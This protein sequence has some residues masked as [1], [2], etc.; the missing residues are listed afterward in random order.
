[1][2][3]SHEAAAWGTIAVL[4]LIGCCG[5]GLAWIGRKYWLNARATR[6]G[7]G[8]AAV[9]DRLDYTGPYLVG[10][11]FALVSFRDSAGTSHAAKLVL[12]NL[13][14]NRL[15]EGQP[16]RILYSATDPQSVTL[17]GRRMRA[18]SEAAGAISVVL[19]LLIAVTAAWILVGGLL[20]WGGMQS[21]RPSDG[22]HG[23][24]VPPPQP[25]N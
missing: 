25:R 20:G 12:P 2:T 13:Q 18:L 24:Y 15:R 8:A 9:I 10:R 3:Q 16:I 7:I 21:L 6:G 1:M 22:Q 11:F 19:G 23:V 14:W 17:G 5:V 4:V